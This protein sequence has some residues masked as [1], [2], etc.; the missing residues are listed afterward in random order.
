MV[1][2]DVRMIYEMFVSDEELIFY[3]LNSDISTFKVQLN[4]LQF[5]HVVSVNIV[6]EDLIE[7]LV[8]FIG[9]KYWII[10]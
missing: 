6:G 2:L 8:N 1:G 10:V 5:L 7:D 9:V 4:L 3:G